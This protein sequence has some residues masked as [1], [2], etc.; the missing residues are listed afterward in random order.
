MHHFSLT[1]A[2]PRHAR[3]RRRFSAAGAVAA[4]VLA[5]TA[6]STL[7]TGSA[8]ATPP[9]AALVVSRD[10]TAPGKVLTSHRITTS[11]PELLVAFLSSDTPA[12][13]GNSFSS[14]T[15]CG[16]SWSRVA[17]ANGRPGVAEVWKAT[18]SAPLYRCSLSAT[19][20]FGSYLGSMTV[21]GFT[22]AAR[23]GAVATASSSGAAAATLT[24]LSNESLVYAVGT[25]WDNATSRTLLSGQKMI[26]QELAS[27]GDTYWTQSA[28]T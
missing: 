1:P 25:D 13:T 7:L 27:V 16:L 28:G 19:R 10:Q 14:L 4:V 26:H 24:P 22:G 17:A 5:G 8:S 18:A 21:V 2:R 11:S 3:H 23:I 6:G 9:T 20:G 12:T 15:G